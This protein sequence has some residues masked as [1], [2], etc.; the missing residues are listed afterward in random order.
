VIQHG[1]R[2]PQRQA[3][4]DQGRL[5]AQESWPSASRPRNPLVSDLEKTTLARLAQL[6]HAV[7]LARAHGVYKGLLL[8]AARSRASTRIWRQSRAD[9]VVASVVLGAPACFLDQYLPRKKKSGGWRHPTSFSRPETGG[10]INNG[11]AGNVSQLDVIPRGAPWIRPS[12]AP[13]S[14]KRKKCVLSPARPVPYTACVRQTRSS[15]WVA[16]WLLPLSHAMMNADPEA[17][18]AS[19]DGMPSASL[20]EYHGRPDG[21][22]GDARPGQKD[23]LHLRPPQIGATPRPQRP[24]ARARPSW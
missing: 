8:R 6:L 14:T 4:P 1:D 2:R 20:Y 13:T 15:S 19:A 23:R 21:A 10:E 16:G 5:R 17:W 24:G 3:S 7:F 11:C 12:S 22:V 9:R 18:P